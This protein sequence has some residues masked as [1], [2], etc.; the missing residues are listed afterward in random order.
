MTPKLAV[1]PAIRSIPFSTVKH[2]SS[3]IILNILILTVSSALPALR[4]KS[5]TSFRKCVSIVQLIAQFSMASNALLVLKDRSGISLLNPVILAQ[6]AR[7]TIRLYR[8]ASVNR[9]LSGMMSVVSL[10]TFQ[11]ISISKKKNVLIA[12][13]TWFMILIFANVLTVLQTLLILMDQSAQFAHLRCIGMKRSK[14][15]TLVISVKFITMA[16]D[17]VNVPKISSSQD[18]TVFIAISLNTL[19]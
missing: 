19:T 16:V 6:A 13:R 9:V 12:Q 8:S 4:I 7:S 1:A 14:L 2:A 10:A 18:L 17:S 15:A 5:M 3:A 11:S